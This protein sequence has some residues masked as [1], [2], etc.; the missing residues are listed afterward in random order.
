MDDLLE[1][2]VHDDDA[3]CKWAAQHPTMAEYV[4]TNLH[5]LADALTLHSAE[6]ISWESVPRLQ[7]GRD[8]A[9]CLHLVARDTG[10]VDSANLFYVQYSDFCFA[11]LPFFM[12]G[13]GSTR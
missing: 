4:R 11:L 10:F 2:Y 9:C 8:A 1:R 6:V 13:E 3:F 12:E 5:V 7:A